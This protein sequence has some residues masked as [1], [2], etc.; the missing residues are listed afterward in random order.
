MV[1]LILKG[2]VTI[3]KSGDFQKFI[4]SIGAIEQVNRASKKSAAQ[5]SPSR[6][7]V[8]VLDD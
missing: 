6:A 4:E 5:V 1:G 3:G 2:A 8:A 7:H